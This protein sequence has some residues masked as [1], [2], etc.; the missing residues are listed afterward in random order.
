MEE[1][2]APSGLAGRSVL[3][4]RSES[5]DVGEPEVLALGIGCAALRASPLAPRVAMKEVADFRRIRVRDKG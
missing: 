4:L 5:A 1:A 2:A 3:V